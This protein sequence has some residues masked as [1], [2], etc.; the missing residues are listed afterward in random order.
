MLRAPFLVFLMP[1]DIHG[2]EYNHTIPHN[3]DAGCTGLR[4]K[5]RIGIFHEI[6]PSGRGGWRIEP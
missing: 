1:N 6:R 3:L 2:T 4:L 5:L